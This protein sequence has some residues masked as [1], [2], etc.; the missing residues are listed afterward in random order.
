MCAEIAGLKVGANPSRNRLV[1]KIRQ[2]ATKKDDV[3]ESTNQPKHL[4]HE[5]CIAY[6][7]KK[8][9]AEYL[10]ICVED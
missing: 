8:R 9:D 5:V 4:D 3:E 2:W 1:P 7:Y 10:D 6:F